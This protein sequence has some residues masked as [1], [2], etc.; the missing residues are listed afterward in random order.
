MPEFDPVYSVV[1]RSDIPIMERE[2]LR[3]YC[4]EIHGDDGNTLLHFL[5]TRIDL[6]HPLYAE[7]DTFAPKSEVT[8]TLRIQH[9]FVLIIEGCMK[10]P[11]IGFTNNLSLTEK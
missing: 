11:G 7:M 4:H 10:N 3:R 5:C 8:R 1:L 9:A 6:S 2:L